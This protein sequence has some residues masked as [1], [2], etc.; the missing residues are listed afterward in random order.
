MLDLPHLFGMPWDDLLLIVK[1]T[2]RDK[3]WVS[4]MMDVLPVPDRSLC[5]IDQLLQSCTLWALGALV[6]RLA[7]APRDVVVELIRLKLH[8]VGITIR[9]MSPLSFTRALCV[10]VYE[11]IQHLQPV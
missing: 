3:Y 10:P 4:T 11:L 6:D 2:T 5:V 1:S 8:E 9:S 7:T